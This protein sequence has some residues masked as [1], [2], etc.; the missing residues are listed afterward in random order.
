MKILLV[1]D[2][3]SLATIIS[4]ALEKEGY[5]TTVSYTGRDGLERAKSEMPN[6]ILLDQV[7]PDI[8]GNQ[9]LKEL[10]MD[11]VTKNIPVLMLSNF[12]QTEMVNQAINEGANDYILKYQVEVADIISKV[13]SAL[14]PSDQPIF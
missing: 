3:Q 1:D 14:K 4:T 8:S 11:E 10:K 2:D 13:K 12:G 6:I 5:Q 9:V 7:L